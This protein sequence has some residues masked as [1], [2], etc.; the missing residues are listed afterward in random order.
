MRNHSIRRN[1]VVLGTFTRNVRNTLT[2]EIELHEF[3]VEVD[4]SALVAHLGAKA[5]ISKERKSKS[6]FGDPKV[7]S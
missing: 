5:V 3:Q 7:K 4:A 2:N 6:S 1:H